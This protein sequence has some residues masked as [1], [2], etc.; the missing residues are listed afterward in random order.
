VRNSEITNPLVTALRLLLQLLGYEKEQQTVG[1][2]LMAYGEFE[3]EV[4]RLMGYAFGGDEDTAARV[5][6]RVNGEAARLD[7]ADA[8]LRPFFNKLNL[9]G[10]WSNALGAMRY[11][12]NVRNQY[13][14]CSW[15][16]N[17]G[18]PLSFTNM[19]KD[20]DSPDG[21]LKSHL[22]PTD[23]GLL[24]KQEEYFE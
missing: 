14:H 22:Y 9:A 4:A 7:V 17:E 18:G 19:D 23:L 16:A 1:R 5:F 15:F 6:F 11:C 13:A 3:V 12:K 8:I 21:I 2:L 20:A 10:Q 24:R